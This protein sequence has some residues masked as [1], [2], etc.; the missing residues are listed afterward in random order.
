MGLSQVFGARETVIRPVD[1][2]EIVP[3]PHVALALGRRLA[4][5]GFQEEL[6]PQPGARVLA[7]FANGTPAI[8]ENGYGKGRAVLV[9]SF[10]GMAYERQHDAAVAQTLVGL[11][12]SAGVA[13]DVI[14]SGYNTSEVEVR[15]LVSERCEFLF[16]FNHSRQPADTTITV[17]VRWPVGQARS[18]NEGQAVLITQ[19]QDKILLRKRL[20]AGGIWVVRYDRK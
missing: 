17:K 6:E 20:P 18:V 14:V 5:E 11:A 10:L 13:R 16:A 7:R 4:G 9:G 1:K 8:V 12:R 19:S 15:R 3:D 2:P